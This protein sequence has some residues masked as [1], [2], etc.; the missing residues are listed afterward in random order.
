M[1]GSLTW[2]V[3]SN[4]NTGGTG[5]IPAN[6]SN[7]VCTSPGVRNFSIEQEAVTEIRVYP[8][9]SSGTVFLELPEGLVDAASFEVYN[10]LGMRCPVNLGR[11][12]DQK[13]EL[14][15]SSFGTGMYIIHVITEGGHQA[16]TVVIE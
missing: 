5:S 4:K 14:D 7:V 8:N 16:R 12:S 2:Q 1:G 11:T 6:N 15:L 13:V 3:T 10:A 9:P